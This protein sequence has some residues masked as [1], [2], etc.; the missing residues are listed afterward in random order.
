MRKYFNLEVK[1]N[2]VIMFG[3]LREKLIIPAGFGKNLNDIE[4]NSLLTA[5]LLENGLQLSNI[6]LQ[7]GS[8]VVT[9]STKH[10]KN[11]KFINSNRLKEY[12]EKFEQEFGK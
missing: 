3:N 9:A 1:A 5:Q 7:G 6:V 11:F 8:R 2:D 10:K 12:L 4:I